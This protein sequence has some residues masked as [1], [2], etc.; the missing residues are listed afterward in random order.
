MRCAL[1]Y[2]YFSY[3]FHLF[4][5]WKAL[6][7]SCDDCYL[8][9]LFWI[10]K[11]VLKIAL[12]TWWYTKEFYVFMWEVFQ[13]ILY[14]CWNFQ[15][16]LYNSLCMWG[17]VFFCK[18]ACWW[19]LYTTKRKSQMDCKAEHWLQHLYSLKTSTLDDKIASFLWLR[20]WIHIYYVWEDSRIEN[21][22]AFCLYHHLFAIKW[23]WI[24]F[25]VFHAV[26][27]C[28]FVFLFSAK[29]KGQTSLLWILCMN[30]CDYS[31]Q[32]WDPEIWVEAALKAELLQP[33]AA[34]ALPVEFPL[35]LPARTECRSGWVK[36]W[37]WR[38]AWSRSRGHTDRAGGGEP[39]L[40]VAMWL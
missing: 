11:S 14:N 24:V 28:F 8:S 17:H 18:Y 40:P 16:D 35:P 1:N 36:E 7:S 30:W 38:P 32:R 31:R 33:K 34:S 39:V 19:T 3:Y 27:A 29:T 37:G 15:Q 10:T 5:I 25:V 2:V 6:N 23:W 4:S 26:F 12:L 9:W 13:G 21:C 22:L 20:C